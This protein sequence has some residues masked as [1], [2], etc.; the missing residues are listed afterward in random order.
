VQSRFLEGGARQPELTN[1]D[2]GQ[3][4]PVL[5]LI[6]RIVLIGTGHRDVRRFPPNP[7]ATIVPRRT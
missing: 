1:F 7:L 3:G 2:A 4:G 5:G 6:E